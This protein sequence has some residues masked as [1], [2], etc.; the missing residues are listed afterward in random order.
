M[1]GGWNSL[2]GWSSRLWVLYFMYPFFTALYIYELDY[3]DTLEITIVVV[4]SIIWLIPTY[5]F[6]KKVR[7]FLK[8]AKVSE[9]K[10]KEKERQGQGPILK[11]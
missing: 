11:E 4:A 6:V 9:R 1:V 7:A 8:R 10:A 2:G 3:Y 5:F